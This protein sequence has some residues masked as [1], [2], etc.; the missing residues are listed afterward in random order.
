MISKM[1]CLSSINLPRVVTY[2]RK[3]VTRESYYKFE[4]LFDL[5]MVINFLIS[6]AKNNELYRTSHY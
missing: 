4:L 2:S 6:D 1:C 5:E 3:I